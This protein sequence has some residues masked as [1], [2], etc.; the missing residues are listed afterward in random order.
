[1]AVKA[2]NLLDVWVVDYP[3]R[4]SRFEV[5]YLLFSLKHDIRFIIKTCVSEYRYL[6]SVT[7]LF[8]SAN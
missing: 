3:E 8:P 6:Y 2:I 5:N 1:M 7:N 4:E